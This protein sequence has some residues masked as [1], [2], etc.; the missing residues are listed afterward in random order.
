MGIPGSPGP[1]SGTA[2]T[3]TNAKAA[4]T[5]RRVVQRLQ[6]LEPSTARY[7]AGL[8]F[9]LTRV[10]DADDSILPEETR[11]IE[12]ILNEYA[13]L[14]EAQAVLVTEIARHQQQVADCGCTYRV[15]RELRQAASFEQR[16]SLLR[17][18]FAVALADGCIT[19]RE[20]TA[21]AQIASE[22]GFEPDEVESAQVNLSPGHA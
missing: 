3:K 21:I 4:Q 15:S 22:L 7:L 13:N 19:R 17:Y 8:A 12:A 18:L 14:P 10:A 2:N 20:R 9:I 11:R 5:V 1:V 16:R 6:E